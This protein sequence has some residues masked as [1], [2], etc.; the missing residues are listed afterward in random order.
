MANHR[1]AEKES[2]KISK[3]TMP[4][5]M[6]DHRTLHVFCESNKY[7]FLMRFTKAEKLLPMIHEKGKIHN[8]FRSRFACVGFRA[9]FRPQDGEKETRN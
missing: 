7:L 5:Y 6:Q 8:D 3:I 9:N 2:L 1:I 4:L